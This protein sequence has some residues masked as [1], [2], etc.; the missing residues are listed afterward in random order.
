[1]RRQMKRQS[2]SRSRCSATSIVKRLVIQAHGQ[3]G[4]KKNST[5]AMRARV[6]RSQPTGS[7]H[8]VQRA[9]HLRIDRSG[10][11]AGVDRGDE[12]GRAERRT[13]TVRLDEEPL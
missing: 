2:I 7:G 3:I 4:S 11:L 9:L 8:E 5:S 1:M 12:V 13:G 6:A 10:G